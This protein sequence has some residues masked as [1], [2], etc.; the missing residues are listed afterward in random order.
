MDPTVL[1]GHQLLFYIPIS[2]QLTSA[3][4]TLIVQYYFVELH[5]DLHVFT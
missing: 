4:Y 3:T 2:D 5:I 1:N